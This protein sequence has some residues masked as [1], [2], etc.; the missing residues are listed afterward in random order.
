MTPD[1][2]KMLRSRKKLPASQNEK[3]RWVSMYRVLFPEVDDVPSPCKVRCANWIESCSRKNS[4]DFELAQDN[5]AQAS[6]DGL[7][8]IEEYV[9]QQAPQ[10]LILSL[11]KGLG[12]MSDNILSHDQGRVQLHDELIAKL[13][14][15]TGFAIDTAVDSYRQKLRC[16]SASA[17]PHSPLDE[18]LSTMQASVIETPPEFESSSHQLRESQSLMWG[19]SS[20]NNHEDGMPSNFLEP[21]NDINKEAS[22]S[23]QNLYEQMSILDDPNFMFNTDLDHLDQ[24]PFY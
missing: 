9:R 7:Q 21:A 8:P 13:G 18:L 10:L 15:L 16:G 19:N 1:M 23:S 6:A 24:N 4:L 3:D 22:P 14:T 2:E 20:L 5:V 11:R 17:I 12:G